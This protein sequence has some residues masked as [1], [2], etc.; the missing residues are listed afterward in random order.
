MTNRGQSTQNDEDLARKLQFEEQFA[1]SMSG[2]YSRNAQQEMEDMELARRYA[3]MDLEAQ[4]S[5]NVQ[6]PTINEAQP[7][8]RTDFHSNN[9][10][11]SSPKL[12]RRHSS[13]GWD[14]SPIA[15]PSHQRSA[16][17]NPRKS[18]PFD[19]SGVYV[20]DGVVPPPP[21]L[22]SLGERRSSRSQSPPTS[23]P[24][25]SSRGGYRATNSD[26]PAVSNVGAAAAASL[27]SSS[28]HRSNSFD[29]DH[30]VLVRSG[31]YRQSGNGVP[32]RDR[33]SV[34]FPEQ[35]TATTS[36]NSQLEYARLLQLE[37]F[38]T[39]H[40]SQNSKPRAST[41]SNHDEDMK[42]AQQLQDLE[43]RGMGQVRNRGGEL[44]SSDDSS[45]MQQNLKSPT[46]TNEELGRLIAESGMNVSELSDEVLL[47]LL[48][49]AGAKQ[50]KDAAFHTTDISTGYAHSEDRLNPNSPRIKAL[51]AA[52]S[53]V[54]ETDI[55][56]I[57]FNPTR[58]GH[59]LKA[60]PSKILK[61]PTTTAS[62]THQVAE[63]L[64]IPDS[65]AE[66]GPSPAK[67]KK[68]RGFLAFGQR[69]NS[70]ENLE[71]MLQSN[72]GVP[73]GIPSME[74]M[75]PALVGVPG[76]IPPP[77]GGSVSAPPAASTVRQARSVS[78]VPRTFSGTK[79]AIAGIPPGIPSSSHSN[80]IAN[81]IPGGIRPKPSGGVYVGNNSFNGSYGGTN[82]C[83]ACGLT[84]GTFL[85][86]FSKRYHPDCFRCK[87]CNGKI[88]PNDQ[89]KYTTD[90]H[91]KQQP[92]HREC[93]LSFGIKC[94]ICCQT[95]PAT[96]DGR[97]PYIKHPFF[98]NEE[99]CIRHADEGRRR[100]GGCQRFE[101]NDGSFIDLMDGGRSVC[102]A[103]CRS[104]V[105]DAVDVKP[106]WREVLHF[107]EKQLKLTIWGPMRDVP[108]LMIGSESLK[109]Q[110]HT[111][112]HIHASVAH[113]MTSGLCL[114]ERS[115]SGRE[116]VVAILC[117]T[118]LPRDLAA[119][120]LAHQAMH[121]WLKL[122]PEHDVNAHLPAQVEEGVCQLT[123]MLFLTDG[124]TQAATGNS[125]ASDGPSDEKLRQ[126]FKYTI[127]REKNEIYGTGYRAAAMVYRD[128][129]I[130]EL[131][132][133]VLR[134]KSF[135][136]T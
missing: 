105:V 80:H 19:Y 108:I 130:H 18:H 3:Q 25:R 1:Q 124:L 22:D 72:H 94:C 133:H 109:E 129:G 33:S 15:S 125:V 38:A 132:A 110:M 67:R 76:A 59:P 81:G 60:A 104:V 13:E 42:L 103:C 43:N 123:A 32:P 120:I 69:S 118:G 87:S 93:F 78:P 128:I 135:P 20:P 107:F 5:R 65:S 96:P 126:Y 84:H 73:P 92:H 79:P 101:P 95:I 50:I 2:S 113:P 29:R 31:A 24:Q 70:R 7:P 122:H 55:D 91:G 90:E 4:G 11:I 99:M 115:G 74:E 37:A 121:A 39:L 102:P 51:R 46:R 9:S 27:S 45:D 88:D 47:E 116:D 98:D 36:A 17:R 63:A 6:R 14:Q 68:R 56:G 57:R 114:T 71:D 136:L 21:A 52:L 49:S 58:M 82:V 40:A 35:T 8:G 83:A 23:S 30:D 117:L 119:G 77:P 48:G 53:G 26:P 34:D 44:Q 12:P 86:A 66:T 85:K 100:C 54:S 75:K 28:H 127:E 89:F 62:E 134:F 41:K 97:V 61:S 106:I 112:N 131:V 111:A 64:P 16:A 10:R